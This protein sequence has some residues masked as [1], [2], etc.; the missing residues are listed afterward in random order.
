MY[1]KNYGIYPNVTMDMNKYV[2]GESR[3]LNA[4][5]LNGYTVTATTYKYHE[6]KKFDENER[7]YLLFKNENAVLRV[8]K[9][10]FVEGSEEDFVK[11]IKS[12][13]KK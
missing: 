9:G 12:R 5:R 8:E 4:E 11:Y 2:A 13:I 1:R 3:E 6:Y 7:Y 10:A